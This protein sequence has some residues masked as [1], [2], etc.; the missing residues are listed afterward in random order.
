MSRTFILYGAD[1]RLVEPGGVDGLRLTLG[2]RLS[3]CSKPKNKRTARSE[4]HVHFMVEPGGVEPPSENQSTRLSTCLFNH[5]NLPKST[6]I[7][8]ITRRQSF[9]Y[10]S[11]Y[12]TLARDVGCCVTPGPKPQHSSAGRKLRLG[13]Y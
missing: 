9:G 3:S 10:G 5:L 11:G 6:P 2:V 8:R 1:I 7:D 12:R 4:P 13:S